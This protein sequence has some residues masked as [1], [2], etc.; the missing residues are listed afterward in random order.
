MEA[1]AIQKPAHTPRTSTS[2]HNINRWREYT[3]T[4]TQGPVHTEMSL[5]LRRSL[6]SGTPLLEKRLASA[7]KDHVDLFDDARRVLRE[8]REAAGRDGGPQF[9][10]V[11]TP[12]PHAESKRRPPTNAISKLHRAGK[13]ELKDIL[14]VVS[15]EAP[16][17]SENTTKL[18]E[19]VEVSVERLKM[20]QEQVE[21]NH[22]R[23]KAFQVKD[24]IHFQREELEDFLRDAQDK[25]LR[26]E[27][28]HFLEVKRFET[29]QNMSSSRT[30]EKRNFFSPVNEQ[31]LGSI[32]KRSIPRFVQTGGS[33]DDL[34][35]PTL[36]TRAMQLTDPSITHEFMVI[37]EGKRIVTSENPLGPHYR[38]PDLMTIFQKLGDNSKVWK[39][40]NKL[41]ND[42]WKLIG[43]QNVN[44]SKNVLVF[45]RFIDKNE[46][47]QI[48]KRK[49]FKTL[50]YILAGSTAMLCGLGLYIG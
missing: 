31:L 50:A 12:K 16:S 22:Q 7:G 23:E 49:Q 38:A 19:D 9:R 10:N 14:R 41:S 5:V 3:R 6:R 24:D 44:H 35:F 2:L 43:L 30:L 34:F 45:E 32:R 37:F 13:Q 17:F 8:E 11:S 29:I 33:D 42:K 40:V 27:Q 28:Q 39:Q 4:H 21:R 1:I 15:H 25:K 46:E 18:S 48:L 26:D 47:A 20:L 36:P